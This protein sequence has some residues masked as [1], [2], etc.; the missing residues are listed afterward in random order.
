[1]ACTPPGDAAPARSPAPPA[2]A[3]RASECP[4]FPPPCCHPRSSARDNRDRSRHAP[5]CARPALEKPD[6]S[7]RC[8]RRSPP[9]R[10]CPSLPAVRAPPPAVGHCRSPA[11][12]R[13]FQPWLENLHQQIIPTIVP[14]TAV[15]PDRRLLEAH[16]IQRKR[17]RRAGEGQVLRIAKRPQRPHHRAER[18]AH[19]VR[20]ADM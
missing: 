7:P 1:T 20:R 12:S 11:A 6:R 3:C 5:P 16:V 17:R 15:R 14:W 9:S 4:A 19:V 2:A 13:R 8:S 18:T 10:R